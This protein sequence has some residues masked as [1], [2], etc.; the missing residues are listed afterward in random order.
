MFRSA[1][2]DDAWSPYIPFTTN[3]SNDTRFDEKRHDGN[4]DES[5]I[6]RL[7]DGTW[8]KRRHGMNLEPFHMKLKQTNS[9]DDGE[10]QH[11]IVLYE[12]RLKWLDS[13]T[14]FLCSMLD[15]LYRTGIRRQIDRGRTERCHR[16]SR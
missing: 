10:I 3:V 16:V 12:G 8:Q 5:P 7:V 14:R 11:A 9:A 6:E 15:D 2:Y 4:A 13:Q 1:E